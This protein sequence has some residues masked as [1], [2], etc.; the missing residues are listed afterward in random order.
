MATTLRKL[1]N[2]VGGRL[3]AG[4]GFLLLLMLAL[5]ATAGL[6]VN[7]VNQRLQ[8]I[9]EV[10]NHQASLAHALQDQINAMA[11]HTRSLTMLTELP[12]I[13]EEDREFKSAVAMYGK[14]QAELH[15]AMA[16]DGTADDQRRL[17]DEITALAKSTVPIAETAARQ[18]AAGDNLSATMTLTGQ[19]RPAET[20][21]RKKVG[22]LVKLQQA[23]STEVAAQAE[24]ARAAGYLTG[25]V[26][27]AVAMASGVLVAWRITRG[28]QQPIAQAL[29]VTESI[30][31]G[32]LSAEVPAGRN[33]ELGQLLKA[34]GLMQ[35]RLRELVGEIRRA[36]ESIEVASSEVA[37][38]NADLSHRTEMTA[39]QLQQTASSMEQLTGTVRHS[40]ESASQAKGLA[41]TASGVA[42]RGGEVVA[43]V[44]STMGEI[45]DASRRIGDITG[46][47][48]GIAFQ[49]NILAL[50][51]AV[52]A[53]RA[54]EQGRGFAVVA[55][56]VRNLAQRSAA[57]A[58]E[59]KG[60]IGRSVDR[61]E[62]GARL[63][64]DAG[65]TMDQIVN[66]VQRVGQVIGEITD[67]AS[68]QS[69]GIGEINEAVTSLDQMTQ[70][71]AALVEQSAAA[72]E[73]L[74]EQAQRLSALVSTFK[75][76]QATQGRALESAAS[77]A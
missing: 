8:H 13:E 12:A 37:S 38:G 16:A 41:A 24:R 50:N 3:A 19:L 46:V 39:S 32:D 51:A 29:A 17:L 54:G 15:S 48:D 28:I 31:G 33:D 57:A 69:S 65:S 4:F 1:L 14:V 18:G 22:E 58:R 56:E 2:S 27:V 68:T 75:L 34:V 42:T 44:V 40:A 52:E 59:I 5:A 67:A 36:C 7:A 61:A 70:Q 53:A 45:N 11:I 20:T 25:I 6:Q 43:Q 30:A 62:A 47:I 26:L 71:N 63:V 60:L 23:S 55:G 66:S 35:Q 49:T 9:V 72:A 74:R 64:G 77:G 21:W 73:S 76:S 10:A